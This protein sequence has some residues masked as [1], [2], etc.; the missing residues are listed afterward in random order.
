MPLLLSVLSYDR[1][2]RTEALDVRLVTEQ[3]RLA[4]A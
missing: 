1:R 3:P 4:G 2:V